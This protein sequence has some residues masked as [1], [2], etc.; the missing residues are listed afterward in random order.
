MIL[1]R[2]FPVLTHQYVCRRLFVLGV[3]VFV[4]VHLSVRERL[5]PV[6]CPGSCLPAV[7]LLQ[8]SMPLA[9]A[10]HCPLGSLEP[11][12]ISETLPIGL[13]LPASPLPRPLLP[14]QAGGEKKPAVGPRPVWG[15]GVGGRGEQ[16]LCIEGL[17]GPAAPAHS[18]APPAASPHPR[19]VPPQECNA[20]IHKKC[21]DKIIGR[22]TGTAANS[23]DTIVRLGPGRGP[24]GA[25]P[26]G[27]DPG[28]PQPFP[29]EPT[30]LPIFPGPSWDSWVAQSPV[31]G[32][33]A[34]SGILPCMGLGRARG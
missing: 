6:C 22:C 30:L 13:S 27:R 25:R 18:S 33:G 29:V 7:L 17:T 23:R 28:S 32:G 15:E 2:E 8:H 12:L 1:Y 10:P 21:I 14:G 24:G 11:P 34:L 26:A 31:G 9:A 4:C 5:G 3:C 19:P 20:A 16:R